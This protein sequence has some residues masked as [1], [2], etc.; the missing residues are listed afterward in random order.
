MR[1][2]LMEPEVAL[3]ASETVTVTFCGPPF[4]EQ[5]IAIFVV[6]SLGTAEPSS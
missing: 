6:V 3:D 1:R 5:L 2:V 4:R